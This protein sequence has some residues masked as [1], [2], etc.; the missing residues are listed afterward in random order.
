MPVQIQVGSLMWGLNSICMLCINNGGYMH[1]EF[2]VHML[3]A[4]GKQLAKE[5]AFAFDGLLTQLE[6]FGIDDGRNMAIVRTKL[7]EACFFAKKAM[8]NNKANTEGA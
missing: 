7:E 5:I 1:K 8:S 6:G 4:K 2:E 3:N